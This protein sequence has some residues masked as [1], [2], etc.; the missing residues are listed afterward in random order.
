MSF[1]S[2]QFDLETDRET[3]FINLQIL[4]G[5]LL[6]VWILVFSKQPRH[7]MDAVYRMWVNQLPMRLP[8]F[9]CWCL[10]VAINYS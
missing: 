10:Y 3:L 8:V 1:Q 5:A 7:R 9:V 6:I 4:L 2:A